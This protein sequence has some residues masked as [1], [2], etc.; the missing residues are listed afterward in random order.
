MP[1]SLSSFDHL[2][3]LD[4][5]AAD[6]VKYSHRVDVKLRVAGEGRPALTQIMCSLRFS[7][8]L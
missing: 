3:E 4:E 5:I 7:F 2:D 8:T 6:V 1:K